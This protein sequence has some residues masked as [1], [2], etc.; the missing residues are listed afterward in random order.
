VMKR[1]AEFERERRWK[2]GIQSSRESFF[3]KREQMNRYS[4][5]SNSDTANPDS[6]MDNSTESGTFSPPRP[7]HD[8]AALLVLPTPLAVRNTPPSA[9]SPSASHSRSSVDG[10][11]TDPGSAV[12]QRLLPSPTTAIPE[13]YDAQLDFPTPRYMTDGTTGSGGSSPT[14]RNSLVMGQFA[15]EPNLRPPTQVLGNE[16]VQSQAVGE[17]EQQRMSRQR[18]VSLSDNGPVPGPEGVRRV[19]RGPRN[20][21][22]RPTQNRYSRSSWLD[23]PPGAAPPQTP[24]SSSGQ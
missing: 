6:R 1:W 23:L 22:Q 19:A 16:E 11:M 8:S 7:R 13:H 12:D 20:S 21:S 3:D 17:L 5:A 24:F 14:M 4:V 10:Y 15:A 9:Q 18:G 2:Q